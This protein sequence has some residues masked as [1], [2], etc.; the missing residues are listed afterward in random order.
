MAGGR[1]REARMTDR[2]VYKSLTLFY[3]ADKFQFCHAGS[4]KLT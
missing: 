3:F 2:F 1:R 4:E